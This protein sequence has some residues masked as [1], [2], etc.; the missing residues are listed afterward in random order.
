MKRIGMLWFW[1][2][3]ATCV[4]SIFLFAFGV[5]ALSFF[6]TGQENVDIWTVLKL[7]E[8]LPD[9]REFLT[10]ALKIFNS[11]SNLAQKIQYAKIEDIQ[12]NNILKPLIA[13]ANGVVSIVRALITFIGFI[14]SIGV[15]IITFPVYCVFF[16]IRTCGAFL[17]LLNVEV[18]YSLTNLSWDSLFDIEFW[19]NRFM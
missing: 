10:G 17:T 16:S 19:V 13:I 11:F 15:S 5:S 18:P 12:G 14:A 8:S 3:P 2:T 6:L 1:I 7:M 4:S 9:P